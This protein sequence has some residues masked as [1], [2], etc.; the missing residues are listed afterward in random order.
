MPGFEHLSLSDI[1][2]IRKDLRYLD[3]N[4]R[5]G[6]QEG[7]LIVKELLQNADDSNAS[8]LHIGWFPGFPNISNPLLNAPAIFVLNDGEFKYED[9]AGIRRIGLSVKIAEQSAIGKFGLGLKS[10]FRLCEAFFYLW[11]EQNTFEILNPWHGKAPPN[12]DDW[13][14]NETSSIASEARQAIIGCLESSLGLLDFPNWLC[15]WIPLRQ[16]HHCETVSPIFKKYLSDENGGPNSIFR[17]SLVPEISRALPLLRNLKTVSAWRADT[18]RN[19]EMLFQI[20]LEEDATR[21]RYRGFEQGI[22]ATSHGDQLPLQGAVKMTQQSKTNRFLYAG[23]ERMENGCIFRGLRQSENWPMVSSIHPES[24]AEQEYREKANPHCA[25]YF[26]ETPAEGR[27]SLRIQQAVF[28]PVGDPKETKPCEGKSDFTLILHGYFFPNAGRTDIEIPKDEIADAVNNETEVRLRWNYELF[29]HGALPLIIPA[30]KQ[31]VEEGNLSKEKVLRLTEALEKSDTFSQYQESICGATQWVRRLRAQGTAWEQLDNPNAEILEIP[32]PPNSA[33][34][35]PNEVFP[36]LREL[37]SQH[38]IVFHG[39]PRLTAQK[40]ASKWHAELL[41]QMLRD[42]PVEDVFGN[43]EML[44]YFVDFLKDCTE[45]ALSGVFD[46]LQQLISQ[47]FA[48]IDLGQL[49]GN[50]SEIKNY[51]A[52]LGNNSCFPITKNLSGEVFQRLFQLELRVLLVPEDLILEELHQLLVESLCDEDAVKML[53]FVS[54]LGENRALKGLERTLVQQVIKASHW[55]EIHSQCDSFRIFTAY[56]CRKEKDLSISFRQLRELRRKGMLFAQQSSQAKHLQQAL[57]NVLVTL[58]DKS[59]REILSWDDDIGL[60]DERACLQ[61]LEWKPALN[62]PEERINLLDT[63]LPQVESGPAHNQVVRYLVHAHPADE[64]QPLFI[65]ASAGQGLWSRIAR[66]VLGQ[67]DEEWRVIDTVLGDRIPRQ[68][69]QPLEIHTFDADGITQLILKVGPE[70]V[71][72]SKF[73]A[74][75]REQILQEC[76]DFNVLRRLNIYDDVDDVNGDPVRINPEQSYWQDD[77]PIEDIPRENITILRRLPESISWKQGRLLNKF[78]N[79]EAAIHIVLAT[80]NPHQ[81][82]ALVLSALKRMDSV[83]SELNQKLRAVKW[84]LIE[85]GTGRRPQDVI[86]LM[87]MEDDVHRIVC[88]CGGSY[89][90]VLMLRAELR[91]HPGYRRMRRA[92][93]PSRD[94]ALEMLGEMMVGTEKYRIGDIDVQDLDLRVFLATLEQAAPQLMQSHSMLQRVYDAFGEEVCRERLLPKLSRRLSNSKT[95]EILN[96]LSNHHEAA[97]RNTKSKILDIFNQYLTAATKTPE[98]SRMLEQIR[99]LSRDGNWKSPAEL[100]LDAEGMQCDDLLDTEQ[101]ERVRGLVQS[102]TVLEGQQSQASR[103]LEGNEQQQFNESAARLEQYFDAWHGVVQ[104][105]VVGGFLAL[106]GNHP[107]LLELSE[108]Y[109]GNRTVKGVREQLDLNW[110]IIPHSH[111]GGANENIH[112]TMKKQRFLVEVDE[113]DTI[114]VTNLLGSPFHARIEQEEFDSLFV[115]SVN[116]QFRHETGLN[117]RVNKIRLRLVQP[118]QF[119]RHRL[120]DFI[121]NSAGMLLDKVYE[122]TIQNLDEIFDDLAQSEQLDIKIAQ[123]LLLDS[124]FFY[125][126][127]LEMHKVDD[128][129]STTLQKWDEARRLRTEA[130]HARDPDLV[131]GAVR[132]LQ[133]EQQELQ[134]LIQS[135]EATQHS[136]VTAVRRKMRQYQYTPQSVPFELFQNADDALEERSEMHGNSSIENTAPARFV[137]QEEGDK[138][139]FIHWGRA[140]NKFRSTQLDGRARGFHKDLE[141][142]LILS[143]SDKSESLGNVTGKFGLGFKSVFLVANKPRVASGQLGFETVG[144]FFP[145]QLTGDPLRELQDEIK[146]CPNDGKEGTIISLQ[147]EECSVEE[148]LEDFRNVVHLI[149][150]FARRIRRCDWITDGRPR[151]WKWTDKPLGQCEDVVV[152]KLQPSSDGQRARQTAMVFRASQGDLLVGL[153]AHGVVKLEESIPTV[154]VTVP[155]TKCLDLGFIVNGRFDLDVGRAQ[156]AQDS[157][158]NREVVDSIGREVG[159]SLIELYDEA[160]RNWDEFCENLNLVRDANRY[161]FWHSLWRLFSKVTPERSTNDGDASQLIRRILWNSSNHG[162]A[163][164]LYHRYTVP[165]GLWGEYKTL[166]KLDELKFKTVGVLDTIGEYQTEPE[167]FC[168]ASQWHQFKERISPG[169][170]VSHARIASVLTSLLPDENLNMREVRLC[171]LLKWELGESRC[172]EASQASQLGSLITRNFLNELNRGDRDQRK[173]YNELTAFLCDVRFQA[174]DGEFHAAEDLLIKDEGADNRDEPLRAAFAPDDR[175]LND[176][177]TGNALEFFIACR[178]ELNAPSQLLAIWALQASG[179]QTR[180]AVLQY[181]LDGESGR[182]MASIMWSSIQGTWLSELRESPLLTD[183]FNPWERSKILVELRL[184]DERIIIPPIPDTEPLVTLEP[185]A[186]LENIHAWWAREAG[187]YIRKYEESV[188]GDFRLQ[189]SGLPDWEDPQTRENWLTLFMLGA[190]H[191]MGQAKPEQHRSFIKLW[192]QNGWLQIAADPQKNLQSWV[193]IVVDF[194]DQP[195]ETIQFFNSMRQF[196]SIFQLA[197]WLNE[198]GDAFLAIN[199]LNAPFSMTEITRLRYS[200]RFQG[201]DLDAPS[202]DRTLGIGACFVVRELMRLGVLSSEHAREHARPH[203]YAPVARVSELLNSIGCQGLDSDAP[204]R[205]K[206]SVTIYEFLCEHLRERAT[207]DGAFDIPFLIIAG[208]KHLQ[209]QLFGSNVSQDEGSEENNE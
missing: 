159:E 20:N 130:E 95:V 73:S 108:Q 100:C 146:A 5:D 61:I 136:L 67:R 189:L 34:N 84:L 119:E 176:D 18:N 155:T 4:L 105:K 103:P 23:F 111:A 116:E 123:N 36:N 144:G 43:R 70:H 109:L 200:S 15:L 149:P 190:L 14:W 22:S 27:G 87:G 26:V 120:L 160:G 168:Q 140:I 48:T 186:V 6:D 204:Q 89:V 82:W 128:D 3:K 185:S 74:D 99:L 13:E 191:T 2:Q 59:T 182:Q 79:A 52:L 29:V 81:H 47:A 156:L 19:L 201:T 69:W 96:S 24:G 157:R 209:Q 188:Y 71:D 63:L 192:R 199:Y 10:V 28:L 152:G 46:V 202:I 101:S 117:Y 142:M 205:W 148:C 133:R 194:L 197:S 151:S 206:Q 129:L 175:L 154:W 75:K 54:T 77:F 49:R 147:A 98:F 114:E 107:R 125:V 76:D 122:Q 163:K 203:C 131:N 169:Q 134:N 58:I 196:V 104:D 45:D 139:A 53:E 57:D 124:A 12:H 162:M 110:E 138:I 72:C 145:K 121:K 165:S 65:E 85:T 8:C 161:Q 50:R 62:C 112:E 90:D 178:S 41:A 153:D 1:E 9:Q 39:D 38:V 102:S 184:F 150:V 21:C 64:N 83:P 94:D 207:F 35:R 88:E 30:L 195:G 31:F 126:Q 91:D 167:C 135:D 11:S 180:C 16:R 115:G 164:L 183:Q 170:V 171:S 17:A 37:A 106:L 143:N 179:D 55:D 172:V 7:F 127:Q 208:D 118:N 177:Y 166:T 86:Y 158:K 174:Y 187:D 80:E 141:K 68:Y 113:G 132:E 51:L 33:P 66:Q 173:E 198:Y 181:I 97:G 78:L 40:E 56:D 193:E 92:I 60:C 137:I 44:K 32:L 93:F 42:V 25:A